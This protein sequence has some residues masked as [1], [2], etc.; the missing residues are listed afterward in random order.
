MYNGKT[1]LAIPI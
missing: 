1:L